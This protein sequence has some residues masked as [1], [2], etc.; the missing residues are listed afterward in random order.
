[1]PRLLIFSYLD[2]TSSVRLKLCCTAVPRLLTFS[3]LDGTSSVRLKLCCTA[4]LRLLIFSF[5]YGGSCVRVKLC[6]TQA[7]NQ[8]GTLA[9]PS[10]CT[11]RRFALQPMFLRHWSLPSLLPCLVDFI[12]NDFAPSGILA[13]LRAC[14]QFKSRKIN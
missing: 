10:Q 1:M 6:C 9:P 4:V 2:G 5:P 13:W 3:S 11:L 14:L 7:G 8:S 12:A